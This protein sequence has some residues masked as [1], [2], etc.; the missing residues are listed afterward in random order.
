MRSQ[1]TSFIAMLAVQP[2][3]KNYM[4]MQTNYPTLKLSYIR[5]CIPITEYIF[6]LKQLIIWINTL[7][8]KI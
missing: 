3:T 4:G 8:Y 1:L 7:F 5:T 2:I 6:I